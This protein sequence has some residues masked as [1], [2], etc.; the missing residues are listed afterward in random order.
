MDKHTSNISL[1]K[2]VSGGFKRTSL[3][4]IMGGGSKD[5]PTGMR[6]DSSNLLISHIGLIQEKLLPVFSGIGY[7]G[8]IE[9]I[10]YEVNKWIKAGT[11]TPSVI[12]D[13]LHKLIKIGMIT[14]TTKINSASDEGFPAKLADVWTSFYSNTLPTLQATLLPLRKTEFL[15]E[16]YKEELMCLDLRNLLLLYFRNYAIHPLKNR[17]LGIF[18]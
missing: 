14:V 8:S 12:N 3:L 4:S 17:I 18:N 11:Q 6:E 2:A 15:K 7:D 10:N 13:D 16:Y 1:K 5:S 9:I